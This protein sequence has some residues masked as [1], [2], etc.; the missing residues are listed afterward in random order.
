[1]PRL[2]SWRSNWCGV[3]DSA[4][5]ASADVS[6]EDPSSTNTISAEGS[7]AES[8]CRSSSRTGA[9]LASSLKA[10]MMTLR[11]WPVMRAVPF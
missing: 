11:S 9:M 2:V 3:P 5:A 1:M 6:S 8:H 10:K 7:L 4:L